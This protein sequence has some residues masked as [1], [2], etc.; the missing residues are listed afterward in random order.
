MIV[1]TSGDALTDAL[2]ARPTMVKPNAEELGGVVQAGDPV[3]AVRELAGAHGTAVI[4]TLGA[5]GI[6]AATPTRTWI[7]TPAAVLDGNPTG[8]GDAVVAGLARALRAD[9]MVTGRLADTLRDC[10]ALAAA[11]VLSPAAGELDVEEYVAQREGVVV[12]ELDGASR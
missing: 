6:V 7:A 5:D 9:A 3:A 4:A 11:A 8:A 10:V 1:D 12:R 2:S